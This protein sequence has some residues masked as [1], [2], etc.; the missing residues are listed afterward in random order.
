MVHERSWV[1][2]GRVGFAWSE[3]SVCFLE[4][5]PGFS[6]ISSI[7]ISWETFF[8]GEN[9]ISRVK[10]MFYAGKDW[11]LLISEKK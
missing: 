4:A 10:T 8:L 2:P 9:G 1:F 5:K 11:L 6:V 7:N 3:L